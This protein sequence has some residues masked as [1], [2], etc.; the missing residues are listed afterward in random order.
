[1]QG[2]QNQPVLRALGLVPGAYRRAWSALLILALA[3]AS[4]MHVAHSHDADTPPTHKQHCGY[5]GSFDRG[6]A[7]PPASPAVLPAEPVTSFTIAVPLAP[8]ACAEIHSDGQP[9]APPPFQ[10]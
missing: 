9:R 4:F 7:P 3:L 1:M 5:C 2:I 10:A 8:V 6:G